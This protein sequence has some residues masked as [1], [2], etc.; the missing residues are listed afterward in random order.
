MFNA[1]RES[2]KSDIMHL[3]DNKRFKM[4]KCLVKYFT[5]ATAKSYQIV[6]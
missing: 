3:K 4:V 5:K 1:F 6:D 2:N